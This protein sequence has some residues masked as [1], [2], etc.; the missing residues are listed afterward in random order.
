MYKVNDENRE[1]LIKAWAEEIVEEVFQA[2]G[3][4]DDNAGYFK[5]FVD[6][7]IANLQKYNNDELEK[8]LKK[9]VFIN[10]LGKY[11]KSTGLPNALASNRKAIG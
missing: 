7:T 5:K 2:Y 6:N 4:K 3:H 9:S 8:E 1:V 10:S 11:R